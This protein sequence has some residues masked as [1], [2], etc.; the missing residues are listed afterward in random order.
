MQAISLLLGITLSMAMPF[1]ATG[2]FFALSVA[3]IQASAKWYSEKLGLKVVME[4]PKRERSAVIVLEGGGLVVELLQDDDALP[5]SRAVPVLTGRQSVHGL[6]KAGVLVE[7]FEGT[8]A[9]LRARG[10]EI[11]YG[12]YPARE[13]QRANVIIRDNSGNLI[14]FFGAASS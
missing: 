10:V 2:A 8:V 1:K 6:F 13:H 14:Q 3:D 9:M 7:D 11:A 12:P 5:L 4:V